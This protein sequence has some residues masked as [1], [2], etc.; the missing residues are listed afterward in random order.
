[1]NK[2]LSIL[3]IIITIL[4]LG[5]IPVFSQVTDSGMS[6]VAERIL[7]LKTFANG[8]IVK[9]PNT[10]SID[11]NGL[12]KFK[13]CQVNG[14]TVA[15]LDANSYLA[16]GFDP[17]NKQ[18]QVKCIGVGVTPD[19]NYP[20]KTSNFTVDPNGI[21]VEMSLTTLKRSGSL[22]DDATVTLPTITTG[23][24]V[25][26]WTASQYAEYFLKSDGSVEYIR[27][28]LSADDADTDTITICV[29]D[30][31]TNSILKNRSGGTLT[32]GYVLE[33]N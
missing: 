22:A 4:S 16:Q 6:P 21:T 15:T 20:I 7:G 10:A 28:S 9:D 26:V 1:M 31:G 17:N 23:G 27:L 32:F 3:L 14:A 5:L 2:K 19:A 33:Y 13:S 8:L 29:Y 18:L 12:A 30:G 24:M 11:P 25:K